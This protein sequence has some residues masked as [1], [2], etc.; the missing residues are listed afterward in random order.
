MAVSMVCVVVALG[1]AE[2][3]KAGVKFAAV[4]VY[5]DSGAS[6]LAAYQVDVK[7]TKGNVA[8]VG[9]EGGESAAYSGAPYYDPMA[10][11]H[12]R[13]ILAG[14]STAKDLPTGR[15]RVARVHVQVTGD[16]KAE[17]VCTLVTAGGQDGKKIAATAETVQQGE[18]K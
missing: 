7:A 8:I 4:D 6:A 15:T 3:P 13:V 5:V 12:E 10:M 16:E 9:I 18:G 1:Q 14:L 17:W 11:Q 2:K